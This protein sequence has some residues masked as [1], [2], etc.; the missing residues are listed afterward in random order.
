MFHIFDAPCHGKKYCDGWDSYPNGSPEGLELE[1]LMREFRDKSIAFT[2]IKLNEQC[3]KMIAAMQENHSAVHITDLANATQ[4]KSA[5]EVT[6]MF[7]E[8]ASFILRAA[9]GGKSAKG[10]SSAGK[11]AAAKSGKPLWD[12][13]KLE[14]DD[15]FSCISYLQVKK[16]DGN[17]INVQNQQGGE[18]LMTKDIL[19]KDMWSANHFDKEVK[20]NM[21]DLSEILQ[22]CKDTIFS[23]KFKKKIAETNI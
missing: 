22:Q 9:V 12:P 14:V 7:V 20:C 4:T 21:S 3:N 13:K 17:Q 11:R 23:V 1:P 16:I 8:S 19:E 10:K 18:W 6:K 5:D 2:C 15:V